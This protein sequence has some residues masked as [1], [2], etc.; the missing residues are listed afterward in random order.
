GAGPV[1]RGRCVPTSLCGFLETATP[2]PPSS[3]LL[4]SGQSSNLPVEARAVDDSLTLKEKLTLEVTGPTRRLALEFLAVDVVQ[5]DQLVAGI[6]EVGRPLRHVERTD[7]FLPLRDEG[8]GQDV[9]HPEHRLL[10]LG[11]EPD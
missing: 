1:S 5:V 10:L 7:I 8:I 4:A 9:D 2:A 3:Q 6:A 11:L